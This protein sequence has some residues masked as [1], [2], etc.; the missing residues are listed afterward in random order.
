MCDSFK[1]AANM[2]STTSPTDKEITNRIKIGKTCFTAVRELLFIHKV[3]QRTGLITFQFI[4]T[5]VKRT[6]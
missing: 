2:I 5:A 6:L 3:A 1:Y 4:P